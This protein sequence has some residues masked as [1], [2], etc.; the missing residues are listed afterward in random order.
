MLAH[1]SH[2]TINLATSFGSIEWEKVADFELNGSL[3]HR[4]L[5][6]LR[7][8]VDD[9]TR[10]L[11]SWPG[12]VW[13]WVPAFLELDFSGVSR[14]DSIPRPVL[15]PA[16]VVVPVSEEPFL[17]IFKG[18]IYTSVPNARPIFRQE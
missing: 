7:Q 5:P 2:H 15:A 4:A 12:F 8:L 9:L 16:S 6:P 11:P 1:P 3:S 17:R 13:R 18:P 10:L 14:C